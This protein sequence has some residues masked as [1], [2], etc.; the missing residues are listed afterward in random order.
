MVTADLHV[1][2][3][4]GEVEWGMFQEVASGVVKAAPDVLIHAGDL[5]GLVKDD[6]GRGLA[7]FKDAG[8][9]KLIVPGNHDLWLHEGSSYDFYHGQLGDMYAAH[10]F[11]MLDRAPVVMD[12]VAFVGNVAWYDYSFAD[13]TLKEVSEEYYLQ[14]RWPKRVAWN[15]GKYVRLGMSD[16]E[17][18]NELLKQLHDDLQGLP[19]AVKTVVLVTHHIGFEELVPRTPNDKARAFCNAF[20]GSRALGKL[21]SDDPRIRYHVSGHT[22]V[23]QRVKKGHVEAITV[24]S[25]YEEKRFVTLDV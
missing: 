18:N 6:I 9:V 2:L 5:V 1:D 12:D 23:K 20:L 10:G 14:K 8:A 16:T 11:H 21:V 22:H 19:A 15:D 13:P 3:A 4:G 7:L 17:F 25:T 24:G